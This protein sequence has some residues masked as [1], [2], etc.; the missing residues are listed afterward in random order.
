MDTKEKQSNVGKQNNT[1]PSTG[2]DGGNE[3]GNNSSSSLDGTN[4]SLNASQ[5]NPMSY[6]RDL[7]DCMS[8]LNDNTW[9][10]LNFIKN[11]RTFFNSYKKALESFAVHIQ[12]ANSQFE[13]DFIKNSIAYG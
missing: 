7:W 11:M 12:K 4:S 5:Q 13:K 2:S 1:A 10:K 8:V 9:L 6:E 3:G